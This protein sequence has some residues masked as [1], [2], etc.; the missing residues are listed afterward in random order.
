[1]KKGRLKKNRKRG[2]GVGGQGKVKSEGG[3]SI[4]YKIKEGG[5][6]GGA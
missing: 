6:G 5:G 2:R 1:M 3:Q 4:D